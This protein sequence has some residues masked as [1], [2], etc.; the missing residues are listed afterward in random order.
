MS[1]HKLTP[2]ED[3]AATRIEMKNPQI[4]TAPVTDGE[5]NNE[6]L[7]KPL[8]KVVNNKTGD[9]TQASLKQLNEQMRDFH[10]VI[11]LIEDE[12]S[13]STVC[14][15]VLH[16]MGYD[17]V[18]LITQVLAAEQH[19]DDIVSN[20]TGPPAAII[21]DLGLGYDSGFSVLRKCHA[22]PRLKK[23]PILVWTKRSDHQTESFSAQ[24]GANDFLVKSSDT[25]ELRETLK[26]LLSPKAA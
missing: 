2:S 10:K 13:A 7:P 21:L 8:V 16:E 23:V 6:L 20:L 9:V 14:A 22:E 18:Q 5:R 24:L 25:Q 19:L 4:A 17:G 15:A 26:R 12:P 3:I 1:D 11:L